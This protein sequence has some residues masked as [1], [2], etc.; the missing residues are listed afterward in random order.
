[1]RSFLKQKKSISTAMQM[2]SGPIHLLFKYIFAHLS[3]GKI[4]EVTYLYCIVNY[5]LLLTKCLRKLTLVSNY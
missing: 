1:M 4:L 3:Q 2:A 5:Y